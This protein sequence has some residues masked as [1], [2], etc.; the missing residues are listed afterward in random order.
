MVPMTDDV[1]EMADYVRSRE[2]R[3]AIESGLRDFQEGMTLD[4]R[5]AL[6]SEL[7]KRARERRRL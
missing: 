2:G 5:G 6:A 1:A 4:G 3:E 7:K